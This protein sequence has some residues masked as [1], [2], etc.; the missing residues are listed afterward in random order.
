MIKRILLGLV[1]LVLLVLTVP[2]LRQR[3]QPAFDRLDALVGWGVEGPLSPA[4]NPYR[5]LKAEGAI[6]KVTREMIRDRNS[7]FVRPED[8]EFQ[9]YMIRKVEGEDGIDPWGIPY[10]MWPTR[11]SVAVVSAGP[12]REFGTDD[13]VLQTIRYGEPS[14]AR[15]RRR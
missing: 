13:D 14:P 4:V 9:A 1:I 10:A 15:R 3:A 5:K 12:D 8:D 6:G 7:G 2:P 11:D